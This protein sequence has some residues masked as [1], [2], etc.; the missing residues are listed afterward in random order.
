MIY[1]LDTDVLID[2]NR[3][4]YPM[5]RVQP[6]WTWLIEMGSQGN[7]KIP[8]QIYDEIIVG[9][10]DLAEWCKKKNIREVLELNE[11]VNSQLFMKV[12]D[13][14]YATNL[15][16]IEVQEIGRDPFL[17]A[18]AMKSPKERIVV[19]TEN[20]KPKRI[21]SKRKIPDICHDF[22]IPCINTYELIKLLD[23]TTDW[24]TKSAQKQSESD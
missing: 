10:D 2:A 23:F 1:L 20:S 13:E 8:T 6:F 9:T 18:Y 24:K 12:M 4:Y 17:I 5:G 16:D 11:E 3:D 15:S 22:D 7:I 19:T 14:G 21:R